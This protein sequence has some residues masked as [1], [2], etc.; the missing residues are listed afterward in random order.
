MN[1]SGG[2]AVGAMYCLIITGVI[3]SIKAEEILSTCT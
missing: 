3:Q 2:E 1:I